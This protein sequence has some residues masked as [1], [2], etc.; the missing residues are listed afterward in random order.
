MPN[1][2]QKLYRQNG[3]LTVDVLTALIVA[4]LVV[5]AALQMLNVAVGIAD[6]GRRQEMALR[7]AQAIIKK[8][9]HAPDQLLLNLSFN[10]HIRTEV[11]IA[12][13]DVGRGELGVTLE[14][15]NVTVHYRGRKNEKFVRL[16]SL[17]PISE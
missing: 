1:K 3:F 2:N 10:D 8:E 9:I 11:S 14:I 16:S 5:G 7:T 12:P 17:R 13:W 6:E 4:A 15:V